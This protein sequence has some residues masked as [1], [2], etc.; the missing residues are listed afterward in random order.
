M[1]LNKMLIALVAMLWSVSF[2]AFAQDVIHVK[3]WA[4]LKA[5]LESNEGVQRSAA[6]QRSVEGAA[7]TQITGTPYYEDEFEG[8]QVI[9]EGDVVY[10]D[11]MVINKQGGATINLNGHTVKGSGSDSHAYPFVNNGKLLVKDTKG[12]G[13][14]YCG[15]KTGIRPNGDINSDAV[16]VMTG[17]NIICNHDKGDEAALINWG[18]AYLLGG[19][20]EGTPNAVWNKEGAEFK[21][22]VPALIDGEVINEGT[23]DV[24]EGVRVVAKIGSVKYGS[25]Q[26]AIDEAK[27]GDV[28]TLLRDVDVKENGVLITQKADLDLTIDGDGKTFTGVMTVFGNGNQSGAE[29]LLIKNVNF[30]AKDGASS[31]IV[32]PDRT[33]YNKYSYA[34]NVTVENC[35]F[36][37][38]DGTVDCAAIRHNDGGDKNW[39][40]KGC[41][42]DETMHSLLQVNNV[43]G[44]LVVAKN[45]VKSKNGINLNSCTNVELTE[46]TFEVKGYAVRTGV[47]SGGNPTEA[48]AF[49]FN[50]NTLKTD[51]SEG[52]AVIVFRASSANAALSMYRNAVIGTT[53]I[54]GL[55]AATKLSVDANY[56]DANA[57]SNG[58][59]QPTVNGADVK[60]NSYY[61]D[62]ARTKLNRNQ[63]GTIS[64]FVYAKEGKI[65]GD[66]ISNAAET[67]VIEIIG[68]DGNVIG[69][70]ESEKAENLTGASKLLTWRINLG[71]DDSGSWKMTWNEGAPS[72]MNMPTKVKLIVDGKE[73]AEAP[74]KLTAGGD[75]KSPVF[76]AKTDAN[77]KILSFIACEGKYNL[78]E[79]ATTLVNSAVAGDH[80]AILVAGTYAVPTNKDLTITGAVEGVKFDMSKAVAV[81]SSMTFND[82]TF[83][84][85]SNANYRGLQHAGTMVYK[86]CTFNG[87]VTLY[88]ESETFNSCT[89]NQTA[90]Q[91]NVWTYGA[92]DATFNDCTFE[93]AGKSVLIYAEGASIFNNVNVNNATFKASQTVDGKAA[94]E[95]DTELTAGT[96]LNIINSTV[97]GF[98][99][100]N[101]SGNS[102]WNN[103][104]GDGTDANKN[105]D[106]TVIVDGVTVLAPKYEAK[107]GD[108]QYRYLTDAIKNVKN[109]ETITLVG[110]Y[111]GDIT[112]TQ[113]PD[114]AFT[115]D[116]AKNTFEGTI[117][118]D[119]KSAAY[120]TAG[121]TIKNVNFL[122]D[123]ITKD[124]CINL[125][126]NNAIRY[127]SNV[128]VEGCTFKGTNKDKVGIKSYTGGDKK[129][130]IAEC[131]AT[132]MH[133]LAQVKN[134]T[135]VDVRNCTVENSKNGIAF[136]QSTNVAVSGGII[137]TEGYGIRVDATQATTTTVTDVKIDANI[138]VIARK[139]SGSYNIEFKGNNDFTARNADK[140]WIA[141]GAE[142]LYDTDKGIT[143]ENLGAATGNMIVTLNGGFNAKDADGNDVAVI[144]AVA[145]VANNDCTKYYTKLQEAINACAK[146]DNTV[147]LLA[148]VVEDVTI[149]QQEGINVVLEGNKNT[150]DGTIYIEGQSRNEGAE[151][152]TIKNVNFATSEA[153]HYFIDSNSTESAKR[154]AHNVTIEGCN[155][156][157][158]DAA[159]NSAVAARIRQGFDIKFVGGKFTGLHSVLQGYGIAGVEL[160]GV[161][162]V[163][164]KGGVSLGTSTNA[165]VKNVKFDCAGYGI[166]VD[167]SVATTLKVEGSTI[168][169]MIP[170]VGRYA[171]GDYNI[172]FDGEN[173]FTAT[174]GDNNVWCVVGAKEYGDVALN[175]VGAVTSN[176]TVT[177]GGTGLDKAGIHAVKAAIGNVYY[178]SFADALAAAKAGDTITLLTDVEAKEVILLDKSITINGN[179]KTVT[180]SATRVFR[181]TVKDVEVTLNDVNMVSSAKV[182]YP[183][184]IRGISIDDVTG[185]KLTLNN[186]SV[187]FTDASAHDWSYAVNVVGGSGHVVT[188]NGGTYEGANVINVR[189]ANQ[190]V[191]VEDAA[192]TSLYAAN[193]DYYG[194]CIYV[195][196]H[197][198][199]SVTAT[200]NT[201]NGGHAIAF[202]V[203]YT[204]LTESD[205]TDNTKRYVAKADADKYYY[206]FAEAVAAAENTVKLLFN[207]TD[208]GV[209]INKSVTIDFNGKTYTFNEGV[210]S[211]G[212]P[213]NGFQILKGNTVTLKNGTLNV[214][215]LA[216]DKFYILVQNYANLTVE[217][218][219]LDG[220]NLD[221][222]SKH[223][224]QVANGDSYVLSNNSGTVVVKGNT[225]ITA[226][227]EGSKAYA[228]DACTKAGYDAPTVTVEQGVTVNGNVE[229]SAALNFAGTLNGNVV[230]NGVDGKVTTAQDKNVTTTVAH[231]N[232][233]YADGAYA[234]VAKIYVAQV[235]DGAKYESLAEALTAAEDKDV[236]SLLW[237]EGAAPIAMNGAVFG[238]NVT[239]TGTALVDW[240]KGWFFVGRGGEGNATVT[241]DGA[242][243]TSVSN[244]SDHGIHVSGREKNT[245]N[246]YDGTVVIKNSTIQLDYLINKGVMTLD[247]SALT[248]KNGF[249]LGGRPAS[250]TESGADATATMALTN[251]SKLVV[252][253]YNG[254][255][256]GHE[257]I[258][259]MNIDD[260]STF[261]TTQKFLITAKGTMNV[262]G[263]TVKIADE[264]ANAGTVYVTGEANLDATVTGDGWFYMNGVALD[265]DTKLFGAKVGFINGKNT[266][267]GSTLTN[268][269]FSVGIGQNAAAEAAATFAAA[270]GITLGDVTVN[271]SENA[272]IAS[273]GATYSGWVGSAYSADKTQKVYTLNI[274]N[275]QARFGY[276]HVSKDGVLNV[277]GRTIAENKYKEGDTS[278]DFYAGD[279]IVNGNVAF[280]NADA[281]AKYTKMS[282]DHVGGVLNINGD[283]K[284]ESSI[285]NGGNTGATLKFWKAGKV[286]VAQTATMEIDNATVLVDGAELN[287]AGYAT[288]KGAITGNGAIN[289]TDLKAKLAAH[290]GLTINHTYGD[291]YKV[292]RINGVY[293]IYHYVAY[294][295]RPNDVEVYY[296]SLEAALKALNDGETLVLVEDI[297]I[298]DKW[299]TFVVNAAAAIDGNGKKLTFTGEVDDNNNYNGIFR[300]ENNMT[301]KNLTIDA[302][303]A[304]GIQRAISA[305]LGITVDN[306]KFIG[307][308]NG[309]AVIFGEGADLADLAKV[310]VAITNSEFT[311]WSKGISDNAN[312]ED[313]K[314]VSIS[315]NS[316]T[317]ASVNVSASEKVVFT[318]N[319]VTE[320]DVIITSYSNAVGVEVYAGQTGSNKLVT[321]G[322]IYQIIS[323]PTNIYAQEAFIV[324]VANIGAKYY[325]TLQEAFNVVDATNNTIILVDDVRLAEAVVVEG[326]TATLD[327]NN[328]FIR[329]IDNDVTMTGGLI[330]LLEGADL[331]IKGE[332]AKSEINSNG[333]PNVYTAVSVLGNNA[334]LTVNSGKL[335]GYYY[336]IAGNGNVEGTQVII[337][338]GEIASKEATGSGIYH[339]QDGALTVNGG[340]ITGATGIYFKS[341]D[342]TITDGTINGTGA[343]VAYKHNANG[344]DATGD[345]LV[346]E[347]VAEGGYEAI[348][349]V[350]ITGG[351]FNSTNADPI[352]SYGTEALVEFLGEGCNAKF[353]KQFNE[354][355]LV[356]GYQLKDN[357]GDRYYNVTWTN[358]RETM[359]LIDGEFEKYE[360]AAG[361][362]SMEVGTLTYKRNLVSSGNAIYLPF[363]V[364]MSALADYDVSYINDIR[365]SDTN[366]DGE[367]DKLVI[368][369]IYIRD[370]NAILN[371][372]YP[373]IITPKTTEAQSLVLK[374]QDV[375]LTAAQERT[376]DCSSIHTMYKFTG[377]V[378]TMYANE[379]K[380][381]YT[382]RTN[383]VW[384]HSSSKMKP[385][386]IYFSITQREGSPVKIAD[387][388]SISM[389]AIGENNGDTT[390]IY[391]VEN[392]VQSVD[393]IYDLQ[394]RRV[395]EPQKGGIYI[396]NGKK[397]VF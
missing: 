379:L 2:S 137:A 114:M 346:I 10:D 20:I 156:T 133:S 69:K 255:G 146:G 305:K 119:G 354:S 66:V 65:S 23:S 316:F 391:D 313:A 326:K 82:V 231:Y 11:P 4:E 225:I 162:A 286:N 192:L 328:M 361:V 40:V 147:Y 335:T 311:N 224:D 3:S 6:R 149:V 190:T 284:Y 288:A 173:S 309:Y 246:K 209:V 125:G 342:L 178:F 196:Q 221:K 180:S 105:N 33:V 250:E 150:F 222:W 145:K 388:L 266:V 314:N 344:C 86:N 143:T 195:A 191:T 38:G 104:K 322:R 292:E 100:G 62:E 164:C 371:A 298:S 355:L 176:A 301:V 306:S 300:F 171:T 83:E 258:G 169:A 307:N 55:T 142:E 170:V 1:K 202:N 381:M 384:E 12:T 230:I 91:Y 134:V 185:V 281:W 262:N 161:E 35:T 264:L 360:L 46:N 97:D 60:V 303:N 351:T 239:I 13:A 28:V 277:D 394:G 64:A 21:A 327:L 359:V 90:N 333:N 223:E 268:G 321:E 106:I 353:N 350:S 163:G 155:F 290:E 203:G 325:L 5:A 108:T 131:T 387:N 374:L 245:N 273:N 36:T 375:T 215:A 240:T 168:K 43:A 304:T 367:V 341:G 152:L 42:V 115:I 285:H 148:A 393:Y 166:R 183:S 15:I 182:V 299:S 126:G 181:V 16:F 18:I 117:T 376:F 48:K 167:A 103:K 74:V 54:S 45:I 129:L 235:N 47:N 193:D 111:K 363:E 29:T 345:A 94:I 210:G 385:F 241:F 280:N 217:N 144:G 238:K 73:V 52:D 336:G 274:N 136:G 87:Q 308:G 59:A 218:M 130:T 267:K 310:E 343:K 279:L 226:N 113:A 58:D 67:L 234:L 269:W 177:L 257:A 272:V 282:V 201:F 17:G 135:G 395:L 229:A 348:G 99:A 270:N 174:N 278:V 141:I 386:R 122:A 227:D 340:T 338:G 317:N 32:S 84:Y 337:N 51:N 244:S 249:S 199:S 102:L 24:Q 76:A 364:P 383:D 128:T 232:V 302:S 56:W 194:A 339:P 216:A 96:L 57:D 397:I 188:V 294:I 93:S 184:D 44:K 254:M 151:T 283:A 118:V 89:F 81:H 370:N 263:G 259:V 39:T 330:R 123:G 369:Y 358:Y 68:A 49:V 377:N 165:V 78:D 120:A 85:S 373:Y 357:D 41:S 75:G 204:S 31:C 378:H 291:S 175:E 320:G 121:L 382:L 157:A 116:G 380:G 392:D 253:N 275:S 265:A 88:G 26:K 154:Y 332:D 372:N 312:G 77:G 236:V 315:K 71:A 7:R 34:H 352:A 172:V 319:T 318:E 197:N 9:L 329:P 247:N 220:T 293:G 389:R 50:E 30:V 289:F 200:G 8:T 72:A 80:I 208:K 296:E 25:L 22:T 261:E 27:D 251:G 323:N 19:S 153:S 139:A 276:M 138:P 219:I 243:L 37:D 189:G 159:V 112:I 233:N 214:D 124:A 140:L 396:V 347:N 53:H 92:K 109:G 127:T 331:T 365:Q 324:P 205:N 107:I 63:N 368:E 237:S 207:Q 228:L 349:T 212:T 187:D 242:K 179:G 132:G 297:E 211:T 356:V 14:I 287:I 70:V 206:T 61:E 101:V 186:C 95:I 198:E 366:N 252:N 362:E 158:T 295:S 260:T 256:L 390:V 213:S 160:V 98:A 248:V 271:V 79:A 110:T 334:K